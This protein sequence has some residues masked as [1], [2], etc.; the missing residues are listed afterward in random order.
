MTAASV[1]AV[2]AVTLLGT[3]IGFKNYDLARAGVWA[4]VV[5]VLLAL[6]QIIAV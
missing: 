6:V 1:A 4:I 3:G 5:T 2:A